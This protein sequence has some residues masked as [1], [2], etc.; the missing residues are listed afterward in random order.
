MSRLVELAKKAVRQMEPRRQVERDYR[1]SLKAALQSICS[2]YPTG[3]LH[4]L[5]GADPALYDALTRRIPDSISQL[6][7]A[8]AP[9]S[10]F[11]RALYELVAAHRRACGEYRHATQ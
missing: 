6:R 8:N 11:Q 3:T 9:L 2:N 7:N 4:W 1:D 5:E 10:Q